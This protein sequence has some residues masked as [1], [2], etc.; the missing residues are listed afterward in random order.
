MTMDMSMYNGYARPDAFSSYAYTSGHHHH[1]HHHHPY[2]HPSHSQ[3]PSQMYELSHSPTAT[4]TVGRSPV[5]H[6][7]PELAAVAAAAAAVASSAVHY[8]IQ[9]Q[10]PPQS[11]IGS[12]AVYPAVAATTSSGST[13]TTS[14]ALGDTSSTSTG[15][16]PLTA[17]AYYSQQQ[18][19]QQPQAQVTQ[20]NSMPLT[21]EDGTAIISTENGLCYTNLD[22][23]STSSSGFASACDQQQ[24]QQHTSNYQQVVYLQDQRY[25]HSAAATLQHQHHMAS[26]ASGANC[27]SSQPDQ[28]PQPQQQQ[29]QP[30]QLH[31]SS[32][33]S[34]DYPLVQT[35]NNLHQLS[36]RED[37]PTTHYGSLVRHANYGSQQQQQLL[38][39]HTPPQ[40]FKEEI[41]EHTSLSAYHGQTNPMIPQRVSMHHHHHL[42]GSV[43]AAEAHGSGGST[44]HP[45][46]Q[47]SHP[48]YKWMQ[49]KRNVP[50]P[51]APKNNPILGDYNIPALQLGNISQVYSSS[52]PNNSCNMPASNSGVATSA[53]SNGLSLNITAAAVGSPAAYNNNTGRTN[54]TNKQLTELEKEFHFNK[55]LTRA[56]RIEI[57]SA[58][59]LNETQVKI[60]FQNRRMKQ[61]KRMKEG[62]VSPTAPMAPDSLA[63]HTARSTS[64]SPTS[65]GGA[66]ID[67]CMQVI[68]GFTSENSTE[69]LSTKE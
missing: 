22:Y 17:S 45:T 55:Y 26:T 68:N 66:A 48:T 54:F 62:L 8:P 31:Q 53:A 11:A 4:T 36:P 59:A 1:H 15:S 51:A 25:R 56:R 60:W 27:N 29:Q 69:S 64:N 24:Q 10:Y 7:P 38:T 3:Y 18:Q 9:Q 16:P 43:V 34:N 52:T 35:Y 47:P 20:S 46:R 33:E 14:D 49:V 40:Q 50:K 65:S 2:H 28:M 6:S 23:A 63:N 5:A 30:R 12:S 57:A 44:Q 37:H 41:S 19:Q 67:G 13:A 39:S 21:N 61:K 42:P 32:H 58:L